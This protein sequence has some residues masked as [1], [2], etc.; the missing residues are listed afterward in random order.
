MNS[1]NLSLKPFLLI[2]LLLC[3]LRPFAQERKVNPFSFAAY[4]EMYYSY[5]FSEPISKDKPDFL[6]NHKRHH[7]LNANLMLVQATYS[8]NKIRA[9][10]GLMAGNY[11]SNNLSA[12]PRGVQNIYEANMGIKL[13]KERNW[14]LDAGIFPSHIGYESAIGASCW[15]LTRSLAAENSP[16]YESGL[17]LAYSSAENRVNISGYLL[18]GW[19][20]IRLL[21]HSKV[22]A[23]GFQVNYKASKK[24]L[25]NY[26]N[27]IGSA[28][29][30]SN[31]ALRTFHNLYAVY[32]PSSKWG[33]TAGLDVGTDKDGAGKYG[34]WCTPNVVIRFIASTKIKMALRGEYYYDN[35]QIIV[36]TNTL[37]GF[38]VAG[39]S[40]NI[41]YQLNAHFLGRLEGKSFLSKDAIFG[42]KSRENYALTSSFCIQL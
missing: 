14:W 39:L 40:A 7:E 1:N 38:Q 6:Y 25:L 12:E 5:D 31:S 21:S 19:Q 2:V 26:S 11:A 30:D 4:T 27:F 3:E 37:N 20:R 42:N 9:N 33:L 18:N 32:E 35:K 28:Q 24:L 23:I 41:D 34:L 16:Y 13:S 15:T 29:A 10:L 8:R 17:R 22:P 36:R